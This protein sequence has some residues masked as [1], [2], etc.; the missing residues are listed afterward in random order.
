MYEVNYRHRYDK[1]VPEKKFLIK[2]ENVGDAITAFWQQFNKDW[3]ILYI[4]DVWKLDENG[5]RLM[6]Y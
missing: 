6:T 5:K 1:S 4:A 3:A 2:A